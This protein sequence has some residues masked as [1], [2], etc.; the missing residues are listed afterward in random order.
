L[1]PTPSK[2]LPGFRLITVPMT[3]KIVSF[4]C[5]LFHSSSSIVLDFTKKANCYANLFLLISTERGTVSSFLLT[6][7]LFISTGQRPNFFSFFV[8]Y[9]ER[10]LPFLPLLQSFMLSHIDCLPFKKRLPLNA[11]LQGRVCSQDFRINLSPIKQ[12][13]KKCSFSFRERENCR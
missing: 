11:P 5:L 2:A 7:C 9:K 13:V 12:Q 1:P 6:R 3:G 10:V 8:P 4:L